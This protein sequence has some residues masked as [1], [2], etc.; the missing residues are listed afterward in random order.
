MSN[1]SE[2]EV[3][4]ANNR[5]YAALEA[6][7][8]KKMAEVW[9]HEDWVKCVHPGWGLIVGWDQVRESWEQIFRNTE[10]IKI[11]A[12]DATVKVEGRLAWVCCTEKISNRFVNGFDSAQATATNIFKF[13]EGQWRL[14]HHHASLI[15][16]SPSHFQE[17]MVQ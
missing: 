4:K 15:P 11:S 7:D 9:L 16:T 14:I 13:T 6:L 1:S 17:T 2:A 5:F 3:L 12:S 10:E 8:P